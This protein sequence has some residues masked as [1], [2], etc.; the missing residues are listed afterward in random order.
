M[1]PPL[2]PLITNERA[3]REWRYLCQTV[4][5]ARAREAIGRLKGGQRPYP[6]NIARILKV[7][8]P[9]EAL[10]PPSEA[11]LQAREQGEDQASRSLADMRRLLG[12]EPSAD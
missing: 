6:L 4:G 5:E 3:E 1:E 2:D 10:L 9:E 8:L 12:R 11:Q 7:Q